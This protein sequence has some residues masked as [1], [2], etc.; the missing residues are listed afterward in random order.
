VFKADVPASGEAG[1]EGASSERE[2]TVH[3]VKK[4]DGD[5]EIYEAH[6]VPFE[7]KVSDL[8]NRKE[9][10]KL[11]DAKGNDTISLP[12]IIVCIKDGEEYYPI[13]I[14]PSPWGLPY[15]ASPFAEKDN[16]I[17]GKGLPEILESLQSLLN[18]DVN[19]F[20]DMLKM[21]LLGVSA[22]DQDKVSNSEILN[23]LQAGSSL[24]LKDLAGAAIDSAVQ[25]FRP[26]LDSLQ[27]LMPMIQFITEY[28][29][30]TS[31]KG[32]SGEKIAP[33]P[34]ATEAYNMIKEQEKSV[35]RA[36]LRLNDNIW[37][38]ILE[39]MYV[40]TLLNRDE[41]FSLKVLG[42]KL[43]NPSIVDPL[44]PV[45]PTMFE[46]VTKWMEVSPEDIYVDGIS[47]NIKALENAEKQALERQQIMQFL[48]LVFESGLAMDPNTMQEKIYVDD[49]NTPLV[50]NIYK[51]LDNAA[52]ALG[53]VDI[54]KRKQGNGAPGM[55]NP[56]MPGQPPMVGN[57]VSPAAV[58]PATQAGQS[59]PAA[60]PVPPLSASPDNMS[61]MLAG[62]AQQ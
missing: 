18:E 25:F 33:N 16:D 27:A 21:A 13:R 19:L 42:Y 34:T 50:L 40:Y 6:N 26:P 41:P 60:P 51:I 54:W 3:D 39:D 7:Y 44:N 28:I 22:V 59:A 24:I 15:K 9:G 17:A 45:S 14:Q 57:A 20:L 53:Q 49:A 46:S 47:F 38:P 37:V 58:G 61:A 2:A 55:A 8:T 29:K 36:A 4:L 30:K 48:K 52:K 10:A 35:N 23:N 56:G 32:P 62:A 1:Q 43:T 31:R 12:S 11:K 5:V